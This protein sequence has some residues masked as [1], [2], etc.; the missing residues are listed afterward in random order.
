M[1]RRT[2]MITAA[3]ANVKTKEKLT[4]IAKEF[5]INYAESAIDKAIAEGKFF[6]KPS[7]EGV[8]NPEQTGNEVVKLL[9]EQGFEAGHVYY[10]G[11][12]GYENHILIKWEDA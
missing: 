11:P 4:Q 7:F 5:I 3:E 6:A 10:D 1:R 8:I 2:N 9:Q 12:N